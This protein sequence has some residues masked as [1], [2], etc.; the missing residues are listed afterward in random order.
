MGFKNVVTDPEFK[1]FISCFNIGVTGSGTAQPA[2]VTF[3][4]AYKTR[5]PGIYFDL[6]RNITNYPIP[7][8]PL[9]KPPTPAPALPEKPYEVVMPM[10][11]IVEDMKYFNNMY[12]QAWKWDGQTFKRNHDSVN[13]WPDGPNPKISRACTI[14]N[15]CVED[16]K[17]NN[18]SYGVSG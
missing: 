4:G 18:P 9:Y 17:G 5:D 3:P 6:Y 12:V 15:P 7:G 16:T 1:H 8:P 2:G 11:N 13:G 14:E 10:G